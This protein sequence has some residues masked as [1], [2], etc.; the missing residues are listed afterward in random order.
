MGKIKPGQALRL[1]N[2]LHDR[3]SASASGNGED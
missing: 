3:P 1:P 2:A